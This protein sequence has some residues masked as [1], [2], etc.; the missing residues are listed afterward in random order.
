VEDVG[1]IPRDDVSGREAVWRIDGW[2]D[3]PVGIV[4]EGNL[5]G[6]GHGK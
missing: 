1:E 2:I 6:W 3:L 4:A 5:G